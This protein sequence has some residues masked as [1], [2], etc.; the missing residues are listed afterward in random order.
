MLQV[1]GPNNVDLFSFDITGIIHFEFVPR[2]TAVSRTLSVEV[3]KRS[4]D[5][6][7]RKRRKL[8]RDRPLILHH[9]NAQ[10]YSSLRTSQFLVG[11]G[12]STMD[13]LPYYPDLA[14]ADF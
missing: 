10:A 11:K 3:L 12:I 2:G 8:W 6:L 1:Q 5:A 9:D 7:R 13:P 14:P 4:I